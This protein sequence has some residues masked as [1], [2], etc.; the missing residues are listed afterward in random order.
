MVGEGL[1]D[2]IRSSLITLSLPAHTCRA[3]WAPRAG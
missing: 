3:T 2:E 1:R